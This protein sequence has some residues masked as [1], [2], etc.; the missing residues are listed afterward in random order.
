MKGALARLLRARGRPAAPSFPAEFEIAGRAVPLRVREHP[1]ARRIVMRLSPCGGMLR[2]TVP[3]R[4][5]SQALLSFLDRHSAWADARLAS[6]GG[7]RGVVDGAFLPLR[8]RD[9][10]IRHEPARRTA[11]L[12]EAGGVILVGGAPEHLPRRVRD[13]L[14]REA[15][16]DL[17]AAVACHSASLGIRPAAMALKDTRSRWGSCSAERRLSFSWRIVMAPPHVLDYLAAHE[18]A[19][20]KEMNHGPDFWALCRTLCPR[21]DEGRDWLKRHGASLHAVRFD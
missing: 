6:A 9:V 13:C 19:H 15:R 1:T 11:R 7:A 21:M 4:T 20:L 10:L 5:S 18:V 2:I 14:I 8:G 16:R 12:D 3:R 17:E